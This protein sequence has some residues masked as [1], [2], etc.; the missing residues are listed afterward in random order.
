[1]RSYLDDQ[2]EKIKAQCGDHLRISF[3][4]QIEN[5]ETT[6]AQGI[7]TRIQQNLDTMENK[8][9][10]EVERTCDQRVT[11]LIQNAQRDVSKF[12]ATQ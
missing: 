6:I 9:I 12:I 10:N 3:N 11:N 8:V 1:M 7:Q 2:L 5:W 4:E